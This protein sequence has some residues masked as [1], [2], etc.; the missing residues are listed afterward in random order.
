MAEGWARHLLG[1]RVD[2]YSA[3]IETHGLN[4]LAVKAMAMAGVDISAHTS[5][6]LDDLNDIVFDYVVTVCDNA[7]EACPIFPG[8]AKIIHHS[9][10][11]PPRLAVNAKTDEEALAHY[12]RVRD[13]IKAF[14]QG[15]A[16]L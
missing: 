14:V 8:K 7:R 10:D 3:G 16:E 9:F 15:L 13:E 4:R 1:D 11:D 2:A 5:K 6:H 12:T